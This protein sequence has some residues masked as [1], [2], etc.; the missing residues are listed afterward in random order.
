[1]TCCCR[2][3]AN[4]SMQVGELKQLLQLCDEFGSMTERL[5]CRPLPALRAAV[6]LQ[7]KSYLDH[8]HQRTFANFTGQQPFPTLAPL[9]NLS[10]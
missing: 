6:H 10:C 9:P 3:L 2:G 8:L 4:N 1:M 7:C 5:G